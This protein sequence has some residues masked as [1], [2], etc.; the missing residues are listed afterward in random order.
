MSIYKGSSRKKYVNKYIDKKNV[1]K[2]KCNN[3][4]T[5][6]GAVQYMTLGLMLQIQSHVNHIQ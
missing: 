3:P 2:K 5:T 4:G 1:F 6:A